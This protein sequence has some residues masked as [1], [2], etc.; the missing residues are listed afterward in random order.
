M[1]HYNILGTQQFLMIGGRAQGFSENEL[2]LSYLLG[3]AIMAILGV[4]IFKGMKCGYVDLTL[5]TLGP[6]ST[7]VWPGVIL[8]VIQ[9]TNKKRNYHRGYTAGHPL[10]INQRGNG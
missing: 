6:L 10:F 3:V 1:Q 5:Y 8:S 2:E 7:S 9:N 4:Y